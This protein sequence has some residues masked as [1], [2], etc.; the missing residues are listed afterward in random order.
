LDIGVDVEEGEDF[1]G[2]GDAG[3]RVFGCKA[4]E[5]GVGG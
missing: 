5:K 1:F 3:V 2:G 4:V